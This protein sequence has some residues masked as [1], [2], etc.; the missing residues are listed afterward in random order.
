MKNIK[1]IN[2]SSFIGNLKFE[3][4]NWKFRE[5]GFT[6][7]E[8][9]VTMGVFFLI[10]G[11][12]TF[13]L[14]HAQRSTT[15]QTA[16]EQFISDVRNQQ[17]KSMSGSDTATFTGSNYGIHVDSNKYTLFH[18]PYST[19]TTKFIVN[20]DS[21]NII[22]SGFN[23]K[24]IIFLQPSGELEFFDPVNENKVVIQNANGTEKETLLF[25]KYGVIY[26]DTYQ[27]D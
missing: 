12:T 15:V 2:W 21:V 16:A 19:D 3:I 8:L 13:N 23:N 25:N 27:N 18:E 4:R 9:L 17:I 22:K 1:T 7:L 20:L 10:I 6:L 24:D 5:E 26:Q 11:L 14:A